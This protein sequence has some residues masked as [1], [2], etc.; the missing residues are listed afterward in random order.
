MTSWLDV[1]MFICTPITLGAGLSLKT[2]E[3]YSK[4]DFMCF[5]AAIMS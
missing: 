1:S 2:M 5:S 3:I 4:K